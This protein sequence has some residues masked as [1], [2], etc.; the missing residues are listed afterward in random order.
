MIEGTQLV[1]SALQII[2]C[3]ILDGLPD[4]SPRLGFLI[5]KWGEEQLLVDWL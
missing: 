4:F 5:C 2:R 3:T 1:M